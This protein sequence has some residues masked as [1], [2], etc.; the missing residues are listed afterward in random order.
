MGGGISQLYPDEGAANA[1]AIQGK[2]VSGI[3]PLDGQ[4]L[5]FDEGT[6]QYVPGT[7]RPRN[8]TAPALSGV[9]LFSCTNGTWAGSPSSYAYQWK[10]SS[11]GTTGWANITDE[12]SATYQAV[13]GD[14]GK[15]VRCGVIATNA[16]GPSTVAYSAASVEI[17]IP[18]LP[19]G[20]LAWWKFNDNGSG[21][22]DVTDASGNGNTLTNN[23]ATL[24]TGKINGAAVI[25]SGQNLTISELG[26]ASSNFTIAFWLYTTNLGAGFGDGTHLFINNPNIA[27]IALADGKLGVT[28]GS[29]GAEG[30]AAH[31][32]APG[33]LT[34]NAWHHI[35]VSVSGGTPT[36]YVDGVEKT[37]STAYT[38]LTLNGSDIIQWGYSSNAIAGRLDAA[39]IYPSALSALE[40]A[41]LYNLGAGAEP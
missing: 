27:I 38:D 2:D 24:G 3:P 1:L 34:E 32:T 35:A 4:V 19:T 33:T 12:T 9:W 6:Q 21:G 17:V 30:I 8:I 40:I 14:E 20:A 37:T 18:A 15:Y 41:Q 10:I 25:G 22:L 11:N 7:F 23:G 26:I 36:I 29:D 39:P 13:G 16:N 5:V 31:G 28:H